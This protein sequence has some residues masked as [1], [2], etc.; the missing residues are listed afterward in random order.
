MRISDWSSDVCSSDLAA[1]LHRRAR[2]LGLVGGALGL[3]QQLDG[4]QGDA[5]VVELVEGLEHLG[6]VVDVPGHEDGLQ[7][8]RSPFD[9]GGA[10]VVDARDAGQ[11]E[12]LLGEP[13]DVLEDRKST[14]LN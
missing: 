9:L 6:L 7:R 14:R 5:A 12:S 3:P 2:D 10:E 1:T 8:L 4:G 13:L 11:L